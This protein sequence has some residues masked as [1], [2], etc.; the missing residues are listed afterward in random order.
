VTVTAKADAK[1]APAEKSV[2]DRIIPEKKTSGE[3]P[4]K[5]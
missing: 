2:L 1:E 3:K 4:E 5:K